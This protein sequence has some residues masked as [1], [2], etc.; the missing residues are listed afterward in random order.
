MIFITTVTNP[1]TPSLFHA[2]HH[3]TTKQSQAVGWDE[4]CCAISMGGAHRYGIMAFQAVGW[5]GNN[6]LKGQNLLAQ[7]NAL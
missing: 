1:A 5:D 7:G 3:I 6:A 2:R 4:I